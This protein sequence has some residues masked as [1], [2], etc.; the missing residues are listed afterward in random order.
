MGPGWT[1]DEVNKLTLPQLEILG[2]KAKPEKWTE[3]EAFEAT[4]YT[5]P[6]TDD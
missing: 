6:D 3:A 2:G 1:F 4:G 5:P